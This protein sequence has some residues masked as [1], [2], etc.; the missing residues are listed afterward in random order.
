MN[1]VTEVPDHYESHLGI[2]DPSAGHWKWNRADGVPLQVI[3]FQN[4]PKAG[5]KTLCTLGVSRHTLHSIAGHV[6]QELILAT[7]EQYVCPELAATLAIIGGKVLDAHV[8]VEFGQ[9]F[10]P[11]GPLIPGSNLEAILCVRPEGFS[12]D[13]SVCLK[14][15]PATELV[16]LVPITCEEVA[17]VENTGAEDLLL[18]WKRDGID[19]LDLNRRFRA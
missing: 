14:T 6:R 7:W 1:Y 3:A 4:Q 10:G 2:M 11:A 17:E 18:K 8:S 16:M 9:V 5:A 15:E 19:L 13:L 12:T